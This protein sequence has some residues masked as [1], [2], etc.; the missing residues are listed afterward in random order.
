MAKCFFVNDKRMV[1]IHVYCISSESTPHKDMNV[2]ITFDEVVDDGVVSYIAPSPPDYRTSFTG[3]GMP[4]TNWKQA[5]ENTPNKGTIDVTAANAT[6]QIVYPNSFYSGLGTVIIGP[7]LYLNYT[8]G[9]Q[10]RRKAIRLSDGIPYRLLS[11]PMKFTKPRK[12]VMFYDGI[13]DLPV[14]TQEQ[15]LRGAGYPD[16]NNMS[17]NFWSLKPPV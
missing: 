1:F 15:I 4:W 9:G 12:N 16:T 10:E 14:R 7:T 17:S 2:T 13:W 5:F 6:V 8:S 3:S 11:Y